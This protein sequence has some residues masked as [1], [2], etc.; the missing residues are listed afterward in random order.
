MSIQSV[1]RRMP[2][3]LAMPLSLLAS[4]VAALTLAAL[5]AVAVDFLLDEFHGRVDLG[6][7]FLPF[8]YAGPAI[9]LLGFVSCFSV[10]MN[11]HRATSWRAP[12][13]A[14]ALG[15][16]LVWVWSSNDF[17]RIGIAWYVP[18]AIAWLVSCWFLPRNA[19]AH[20]EHVIEA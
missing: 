4:A 15:A 7:T 8:F 11:W 17:G 16:I 19:S 13:F 5:G 3:Y 10:L 9:A 12:T 2:V 18:G 20:P 14:F 6:D 1:Y